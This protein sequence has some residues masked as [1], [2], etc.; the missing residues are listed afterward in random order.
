MV[1]FVLEIT[2][3]NDGMKTVMDIGLTLR[4]IGI[5]IADSGSSIDYTDIRDDN[6]NTVGYYEVK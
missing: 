6:G 5:H 1:K 2:L 3:G 4:D